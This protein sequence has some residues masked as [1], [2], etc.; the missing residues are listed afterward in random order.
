MPNSQNQIYFITSDKRDLYFEDAFRT[1]SAPNGY[2][3]KYRYQT[4]WITD[5]LLLKE[6][7]EIM[8][9]ALL[10]TKEECVDNVLELI[11]LRKATI[12]KITVEKESQ[13]NQYY[14]ELGE[15]LKTEKVIENIPENIEEKMIFSTENSIAQNIIEAN[16]STCPW[17]S[18]IDELLKLSNNAFKKRV[19]Y[20]IEGINKKK[21]LCR[22]KWKRIPLKGKNIYKLAS[23]SDYKLKVRMKKADE[24][25]NSKI[26]VE[27]GDDVIR[28]IDTICSL[29]APRENVSIDFYT[30]EVK[31]ESRHSKLIFKSAPSDS[32]EKSNKY[33]LKIDIDLSRKKS[34][35]IL[36]GLMTA[37][38][39][40]V[41]RYDIYSFSKICKFMDENSILGF[42]DYSVFPLV[43]F[44]VSICLFWGYDKK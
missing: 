19:L 8:I 29:D 17:E 7:Y 13:F 32:D 14:L 38:T 5:N 42:L 16:V 12:K 1:L 9:L 4:K 40:T 21:F 35:Y 41:T 24:L 37:V 30:A 25:E 6:D 11:P 39:T 10:G 23:N 18:T 27:C 28:N 43:I 31:K 15:Y 2:Q 3:M 44:F 34:S 22:D 36:F 26:N 33:D 20:N